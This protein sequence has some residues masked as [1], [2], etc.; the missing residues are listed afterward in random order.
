MERGIKEGMREE[1]KTEIVP[2][3]I[4]GIGTGYDIVR[5]AKKAD[6]QSVRRLTHNPIFSF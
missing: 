6:T 3:I 1:V 5:E 4:I 2:S